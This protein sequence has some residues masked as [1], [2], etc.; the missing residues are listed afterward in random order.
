MA[1]GGYHTEEFIAHYN[2]EKLF[3]SCRAISDNGGIMDFSDDD[4]RL[5]Q[6]MIDRSAQVFLLCDS[7]KIGTRAFCSVAS[8]KDIDYLIT[9]KKP[10]DAIMAA[11]EKAE[12]QVVYS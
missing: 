2:V 4:A 8:F 11:I 9:D 7:S 12:V 3:F 5:K 10:T 6:K 1:L